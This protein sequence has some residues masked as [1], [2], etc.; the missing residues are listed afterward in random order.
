MQLAVFGVRGAAA[1]RG[2]RKA[3]LSNR[4]HNQAKAKR[5]VRS[6]QL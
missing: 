5:K 2:H 6:Y 4:F 3:V 1:V